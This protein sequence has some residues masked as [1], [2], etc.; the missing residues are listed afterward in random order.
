MGLETQFRT[1]ASRTREILRPADTPAAHSAVIPD[2]YIALPSPNYRGYALFR[3][4][5]KSRSDI[6][7]AV[8]YAKRIKV[9]PLSQAANPTPTT[10]YARAARLDSQA[11]SAQAKSHRS[12]IMRP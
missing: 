2:G 9:Y 1:G 4:I 11:P 3:S 7:E 12:V 10:H 8:A 5:L 6:A